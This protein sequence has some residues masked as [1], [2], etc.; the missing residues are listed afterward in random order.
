MLLYVTN[1]H[2]LHTTICVYF[3]IQESLNERM[4]MKVYIICNNVSI[5]L[6]M[7]ICY[8]RQHVIVCNKCTIYKYICIYIHIYI[9]I[10]IIYIYICI[11]IDT[12]TVRSIWWTSV[13]ICVLHTHTMHVT[14]AHLL[15]TTIH[16]Y[17]MYIL[18]LQSY[19]H[20][21]SFKIP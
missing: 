7:H 19:I 15:H 10:Y 13:Y 20:T 18:V 2:L 8:I 16:I 17:Y 3:V 12:Y 1:T 21:L 11:Y 14:N 4:S 9:Y 5:S 6:Q